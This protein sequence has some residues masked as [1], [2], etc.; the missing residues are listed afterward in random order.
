MGPWSRGFNRKNAEQNL[1]HLIYL[2]NIQTKIHKTFHS[3]ITTTKFKIK[4]YSSLHESRIKWAL[5]RVWLHEY[6]SRKWGHLNRGRCLCYWNVGPII[7]QNTK[8]HIYSCSLTWINCKQMNC[9]QKAEAFI[10]KELVMSRSTWVKKNI[11]FAF[12]QNPKQ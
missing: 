8:T 12:K 11:G 4:I 5:T 1:L 7:V 10:V 3:N 6:L 2:K 9:L